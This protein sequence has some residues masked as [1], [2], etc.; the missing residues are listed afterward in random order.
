MA[1]KRPFDKVKT[2]VLAALAKRAERGNTYVKTNK[3]R[4][5]EASPQQIGCALNALE[6]DGVVEPWAPQEPNPNVWVIDAET[7]MERIRHLGLDIPDG[8]GR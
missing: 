7:V 8:D 6:D 4:H 5:I 3:L 1:R 2:D